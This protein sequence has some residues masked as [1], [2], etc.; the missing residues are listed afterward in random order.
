[1][2]CEGIG[3][4][5]GW[6]GGLTRVGLLVADGGGGADDMPSR[7][8]CRHYPLVCIHVGLQSDEIRL[9]H[10]LMPNYSFGDPTEYMHCKKQ[11]AD[12]R[13]CTSYAI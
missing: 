2:Q 5:G 10:S 6:L 4:A 9:K 1:M 3:W 8:V 12:A 13:N 11:M 7:P